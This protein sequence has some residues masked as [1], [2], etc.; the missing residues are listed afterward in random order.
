[1]STASHDDAPRDHDKDVVIVGAGISGLYCAWRLIEDD[2]T[3]RITIVERLNR[4]GGRLDTDLIQVSADDEVREEEGGMRFNT[5]MT[6]LMQLVAALGLCD[7]I[8]PFAMTSASDAQPN[9]NRF[10]LRGRSFSAADAAA[11]KNAIWGEIYRL[12]EREKGLSPSDL[13]TQAYT[14]VLA[15]N[16]STPGDSTPPEFW[17]ELRN[18]FTWQG[19]RLRDWQLWGLLRSMG[20]SQ[21]CIQML[22]DTVGFAGPFKAPINAGDAFQLL[23][24]FPKDPNYLTFRNG[25]STLPNAVRDRLPAQVEI[26]LGTN[27]DCIERT[28]DRFVL[29]LTK[30]P[31]QQSSHPHIAGGK[32]Q[33]R[34][35]KKVILAV[36]TTALEQ[37][38]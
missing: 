26:L 32:V 30:A 6:E 10:N 20:Y 4:T 27:V 2:P 38:F 21:E 12:E 33:T 22:A 36:A 23:A 37:L 7:E 1:M 34:S 25:F 35:A 8:V 17:T 16:H 24:D 18:T 5:A 14:A 29:R 15:Q 13:I 3:R 19:T 28:G 9:T 11:G 31:D